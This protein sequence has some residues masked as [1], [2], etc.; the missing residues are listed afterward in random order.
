MG[1][2]SRDTF[3]LTNIMHQLITGE[4]VSNPTHY[5]GIRLQQGVPV[6]D[7]D[8]NELEDIHRYDVQTCLQ[9]FYGN[10]IPTGNNGF[11]IGTVTQDN[12]FKI[13]TLHVPICGQWV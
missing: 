3:K 7:A 13:E 9:Y 10:G 1:N 5:V 4:P 8:W 6:L 11:Q 12:N 2:F